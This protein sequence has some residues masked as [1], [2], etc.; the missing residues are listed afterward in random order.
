MAPETGQDIVNY[1]T[2]HVR[3]AVLLHFQQETGSHCCM[4]HMTHE[5]LLHGQMM[6]IVKKNMWTVFTTVLAPISG[7]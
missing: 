7:L 2:I 6:P 1:Y 4:A 3:V 5:Y